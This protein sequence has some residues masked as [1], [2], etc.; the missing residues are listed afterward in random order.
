MPEALD[1]EREKSM[2]G[3]VPYYSEHLVVATGHS[4]WP[5][6]I[7]EEPGGLANVFKGMLRKNAISNVCLFSRPY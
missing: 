1:I 4:S 6:R 7:E 3:T 5:S 2:I